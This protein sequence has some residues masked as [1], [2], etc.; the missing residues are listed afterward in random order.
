VQN[1]WNTFHLSLTIITKNLIVIKKCNELE[2]VQNWTEFDR[3][4]EA[5]VKGQENKKVMMSGFGEELPF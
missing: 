3:T 4:I 2:S 1:E 5:K